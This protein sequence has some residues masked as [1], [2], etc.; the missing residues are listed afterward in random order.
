MS[1]LA[2][3]ISLCCSSNNKAARRSATTLE[4]SGSSS[5]S[6]SRSPQPHSLSVQSHIRHTS[7]CRAAATPEAGVGSRAEDG[8]AAIASFTR[9]ACEA[10]MVA[11]VGLTM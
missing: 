9:A 5:T 7:T 10:Q 3:A 8:H 1:S 4:G 6:T 11:H 2:D